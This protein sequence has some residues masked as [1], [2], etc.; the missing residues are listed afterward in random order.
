MTKY[1]TEFKMKVVKEYLEGQI[2]YKELSK[3]YNIQDKSTVRTWVNAY[4]NQGYEGIKI[5]RRNNNYSLDFKLNVVNLYLTGEMSYQSLAN[6]LKITNPSIIARWVSEFRER[7]IEGLKPKKRGRPSKMRKDGKKISVNKTK[8][9]EDLRE[10]EKLKEE[11]YYLQMEVE[12]LKKK[13][14]I[15]SNDTERNRRISEVIRSLREKFKLKDLLKYFNLP[16]ST[17]MYWQKRLNKPN[18][19]LEIENKILK[20]RKENPNY[21]YRRITAMLK[22]TGLIIN[23]KK[24]QRLVQKLKLQVK[25]YSRKSRKYSSYK[26]QIGKIS[27]NKIKRNFKVEKPYIQ[28]TTDTTEFKYLEKDKK[29]NYQI[30]KL[31]LNPYLDMYNSEILSYEI[32]KQPTIEP[33]LKALDKA[34]KVT[35]KTKEKR[36]FHSDQ[37]WAYQKNQYTSR[38]E[39]NGIIQSMS[40]KGNCL[41]NSPMENFFGILKQEIYYGHKFYSYEHLK[42]TIEDFIKYYNEERIKEKLGYLSPVEY[43]KKNAA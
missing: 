37:G 12:I 27:D 35:N 30:K 1:N 39:A 11:N 17:Y 5:S 22:R 4:E 7:G 33:I 23:K 16:K 13:D 20:I 36:I 31:Y 9:K 28:I 18:K 43:R 21:G 10:L 29:G 42:Q 6:E 3:K 38:L 2:G 34:I 26:G 14:S 24:V 25:S 15:L 41:D 19:D 8:M 40:R 32:S